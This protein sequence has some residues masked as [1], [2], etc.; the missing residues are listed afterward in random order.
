M[1]MLVLIRRK[2]EEVILSDEFYTGGNEIVVKVTKIING[3]I[4]IGFSA[5]DKL[6]I[7]RSE[8]TA[9]GPQMRNR[10]INN[11]FN[12]VPLVGADGERECIHV[13]PGAGYL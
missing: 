3:I 1:T 13:Y 11:K 12:H 2:G 9:I 6:K 8:L 5:P 7:L 4:H 10:K